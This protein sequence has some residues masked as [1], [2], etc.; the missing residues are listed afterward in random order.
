[1]SETPA[2]PRPTDAELLARFQRSTNRP[3]GSQL[4]GFEIVAVDQAA[5]RV[6]AT[7]VAREDFMNPM[8]QVQ[9]GFLCAMLDDVMSVA[10]VVASGMTH[11]MPTL[12]MKTSFLRPALPGQT[13]RCVGRVVKWGRT[14]AF[15]E[16]EI[17]DEAGALLAKATGTA[18]PTPFARFKG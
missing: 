13:L 6:E 9:G 5:M 11:V 4:L 3:R 7:F 14:I 18:L 1:M 17:Y 8:R 15:T 16:G 10:G 12:E 2:P